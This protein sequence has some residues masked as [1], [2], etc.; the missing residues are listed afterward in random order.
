MNHGDDES[1]CIQ[2]HFVGVTP[3]ALMYLHYTSKHVHSI[4]I[5]EMLIAW[6]TGVYMLCWNQIDNLHCLSDESCTDISVYFTCVIF[7]AER[8]E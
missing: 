1:T 5:S 2:Q 6:L 3:V 7:S 8:K 4:A